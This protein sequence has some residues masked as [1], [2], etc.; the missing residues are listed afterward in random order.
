M[1]DAHHYHHQ[2]HEQRTTTEFALLI[3]YDTVI[4]HIMARHT[5]TN[6]KDGRHVFVGLT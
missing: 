1:A 6:D 4:N 2:E 5:T 3:L